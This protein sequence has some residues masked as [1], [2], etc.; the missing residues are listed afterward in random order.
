[1]GLVETP[2][3]AP[4]C[5]SFLPPTWMT[6][7]F[8]MLVPFPECCVAGTTQPVAFSG[9]LLSLSNIHLGFPRP[10][11]FYDLIVDFFLLLSITPYVNSS[12]H[13]CPPSPSP[14]AHSS[15][16][17]LFGIG[18]G[19]MLTTLIARLYDTLTLS[20]LIRCWS[21]FWRSCHFSILLLRNKSLL[22]CILASL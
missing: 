1:M 18:L 22:L 2:N 21:V 10:P 12:L 20:S 5:S 13:S 17:I 3:T 11:S 15:K 8:F 19:S 9:W 7:S 14:F 16:G 4:N 6:G